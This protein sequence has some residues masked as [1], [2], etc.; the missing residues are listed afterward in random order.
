MKKKI[1]L[2]MMMLMAVSVTLMVACKKSSPY[3]GNNNNNPNTITM[4]GMVFSSTSLQIKTG[5]TVMWMNDDNTTHTV[6]ADDGT[7]DSGD[8]APGGS[9][10]HTF[11]ATG[12]FAYHCKLHS[13]MTGV[14]VVTAP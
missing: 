10:S 7:F 5:T 12:T 11:A 14:I 1:L 8:I 2:L 6:T 3:A 4:K 9:F 13:N